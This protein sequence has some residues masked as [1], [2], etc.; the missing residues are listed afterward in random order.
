MVRGRSAHPEG[1]GKGVKVG[2][3]LAFALD[4]SGAQPLGELAKRSSSLEEVDRLQLP[5]GRP[6]RPRQVGLLGV[7]EAVEAVAHLAPHPGGLEIEECAI[8]TGE[9]QQ[10]GDLLAALEVD[11]PSATSL[12][13]T[14]ARA[15]L[16][17][18]PAQGLR[19][20]ATPEN[21]LDVG[22]GGTQGDRSPPS[23]TPRR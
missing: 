19:P 3:R 17:E 1:A 11:N 14:A 4:G 9:L 20:T 6:H 23:R 21:E 7:Q 12:Q 5:I 8:R 22:T 18:V 10:R 15:A 2:L 13:E 16:A